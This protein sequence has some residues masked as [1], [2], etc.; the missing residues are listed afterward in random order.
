MLTLTSKFSSNNHLRFWLGL[1][2]QESIRKPRRLEI[3]K[4]VQ[5]EFG[6]ANQ[7]V[8]LTSITA[9]NAVPT[10]HPMPATVARDASFFAAKIAISACAQK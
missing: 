2:K 6:S 3:Q 9:G 8:A 10:F 5:F 4:P 7:N 1:V